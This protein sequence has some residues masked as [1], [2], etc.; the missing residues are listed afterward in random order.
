MADLSP[1]QWT[2]VARLR[3]E[4]LAYAARSILIAVESG[5][6]IIPSAEDMIRDACRDLTTAA[7]ILNA[8]QPNKR[9]AA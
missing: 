3:A 7:G 5:G 9:R 1:S 6:E 8:R 2:E 4:N